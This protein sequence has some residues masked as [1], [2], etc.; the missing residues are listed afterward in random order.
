MHFQQMSE[1]LQRDFTTSSYKQRSPI[2]KY[3]SFFF[4]G[5][6]MGI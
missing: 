1:V 5:I 3:H 4:L 6:S 2:G